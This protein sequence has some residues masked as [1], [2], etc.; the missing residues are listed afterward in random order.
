MLSHNK[1]RN[2]GSAV[3]SSAPWCFTSEEE[4]QDCG[5]P[6]CGHDNITVTRTTADGKDSYYDD[7]QCVQEFVDDPRL[8][9]MSFT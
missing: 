8:H 2:F 6:I 4:W 3:N 5:V 9:V 7:K 1:C